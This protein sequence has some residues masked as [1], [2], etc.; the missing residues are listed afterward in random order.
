MAPD[1]A[2]TVDTSTEIAP[3]QTLLI[4]L[5][6][7]GLAGLTAADH[8]TRS[9]DAERVGRIA[10]EELPAITPFEHGVP[11]HHTRLYDLQETDVI[12]LVGE[13]FVP[14]F[15][16]ASFAEALAEWL[17]A[18]SV[19][20]V[21]FLHGIPFPHG[22]DEH[23]VFHV[24]AEAYRERHREALE[25]PPMQGGYLDG[26][27]GELV[28]RSLDGTAPPTG[29]F[30]TPTHPPGPDVEGALRFLDT[31]E[32]VYDL[33]VNRQELEQLSEE[34]EQYYAN[35]ADRMSALEEQNRSQMEAELRD[36]WMFM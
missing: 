18:R 27:A 2:F 24:A 21:A 9:R 13:L 6:H 29:V 31:V 30:V 33:A 23:A 5:S 20:E 16:A 35:L 26:V 12:V 1:Q 14:T 22:P 8:L 25:A 7:L 3:D 17:T 32:S 11:R 15:A 19:G 4:G 10:P 34:I 36:D 28:S